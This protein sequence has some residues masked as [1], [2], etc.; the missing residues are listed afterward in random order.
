MD[1]GT[2][3]AA[4]GSQAVCIFEAAEKNWEECQKHSELAIQQLVV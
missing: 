3:A 2:K 4:A 1:V